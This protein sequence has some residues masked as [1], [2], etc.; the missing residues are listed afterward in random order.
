MSRLRKTCMVNSRALP[1]ALVRPATREDVEAF[2]GAAGLDPT[3][4]AVAGV[5]DGEVVALAGFAFV[6]GRVIAFCDLK[7]AAR[8]FPVLIHRTARK[9]LDEARRDGRRLIYAEADAAEPGARRWLAALGF[10]P[11]DDDERLWQ[12][13]R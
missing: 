2:R 7:P 10:V 11:V 4:K 5:V 9:L 1:E 13:R 6:G 8:R 12:W 3:I